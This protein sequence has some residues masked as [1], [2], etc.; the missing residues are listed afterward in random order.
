MGELPWDEEEIASFLLVLY[1]LWQAEDLALR[2]PEQENWP[3]PSPSVA[4]RRA[5]PALHLGSTVE[6]NLMAG[7]EGGTGKRVQRVWE[8]CPCNLSAVGQCKRGKDVLPYPCPLPLMAA[9]RA[10]PEVMRAAELSLPLTWD[11]TQES[12]LC[13][14]P[15]QHSRVGP[16][17]EGCR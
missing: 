14:L 13:T 5:G 12:R 11:S 1:Y 2:S 6:L 16:G 9:E 8:S 3:C 10:G 7:D 15:G 17:C 4:L